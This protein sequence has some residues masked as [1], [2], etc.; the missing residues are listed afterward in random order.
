MSEGRE[1]GVGRTR[2]RGAASHRR[3]LRRW[4]PRLSS[5]LFVVT[6]ILSLHFIVD[7]M[8]MILA[9]AWDL[10]HFVWVAFGGSAAFLSFVLA[11]YAYRLGKRTAPEVRTAKD[12]A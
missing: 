6:G 7:V 9:G 1:A 4:L 10:R 11:R 5:V 8:P 2:N 3:A 12:P